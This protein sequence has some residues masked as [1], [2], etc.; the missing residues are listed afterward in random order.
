MDE[1]VSRRW[2]VNITLGSPIL[3]VALF[4][5]EFVWARETKEADD[6]A[7]ENNMDD[8]EGI[9]YS[10]KG[11]PHPDH[12]NNQI[13]TNEHSKQDTWP[14]TDDENSN[15]ENHGPVVIQPAYK[16]ADKSYND[17][18]QEND[19]S[20]VAER[21]EN[22]DGPK[23]LALIMDNDKNKE[24]NSTKEVGKK[25]LLYKSLNSVRLKKPIRLQLW[26]DI[27]RETF[28]SRTNPQCVHWSTLRG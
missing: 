14:Q 9:T 20:Y 2:G 17:N 13:S 7:I 18:F 16:K 28:G 21:L 3:Q 15:H 5:P 19:S 12:L 10:N 22:S 24:F 27:N 26:L 4:V 25:K 6:N 8:L 11:H 1:S 23:V